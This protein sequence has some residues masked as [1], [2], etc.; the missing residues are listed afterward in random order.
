[1]RATFA[2]SALLIAANL[3]TGCRSVTP[4]AA[5][6]ST[7]VEGHVALLIQTAKAR[8]CFQAEPAITPEQQARGLMFRTDIGPDSA[9]LFAP[10]PGEGGA[11]REAS[12]WMKDTPSALDILFIRADRI[13]ARIADN[14]IPFSEMP[15][16]SGEPVAAVLELRGG[17][18]AELGITE[19]D[20]VSW[21]VDPRTDQKLNRP[22]TP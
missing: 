21:I 7:A 11:P 12:F 14:T 5:F 1:M 13:I 17:R 2:A 15:I 18:A 22:V 4:A 10:Y 9:M 20:R 19:G 3:L 16:P 8:H 6:C